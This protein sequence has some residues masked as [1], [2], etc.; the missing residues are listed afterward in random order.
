MTTPAS[1]CPLAWC[2]SR[3][4]GPHAIHQNRPVLVH[5]VTAQIVWETGD[6]T[7]RVLS[8]AVLRADLLTPAQRDRVVRR[9]ELLADTAHAA[10]VTLGLSPATGGAR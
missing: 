2:T 9:I 10:N 3:G 6:G 8:N 1:S 7:V 5:G 4:N